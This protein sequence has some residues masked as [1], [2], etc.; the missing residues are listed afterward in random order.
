[1]SFLMYRRG[2]TVWFAVLLQHIAVSTFLCLFVGWRPVEETE[3]DTS[4][5]HLNVVARL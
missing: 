1:M 4:A 2:I 5:L 3:A